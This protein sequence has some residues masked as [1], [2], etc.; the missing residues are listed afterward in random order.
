[1]IFWF[2]YVKGDK[3]AEGGKI[4]AHPQESQVKWSFSDL[5]FEQVKTTKKIHKVSLTL[6][7]TS[8]EM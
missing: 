1:V 4:S 5:P 8:G 3:Y 2:L 6:N 7:C